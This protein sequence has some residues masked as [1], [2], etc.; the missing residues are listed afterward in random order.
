MTF[1]KGVKGCVRVAMNK[2]T[3]K[4]LDEEEE[5]VWELR[6]WNPWQFNW[7]LFM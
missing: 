3:K 4:K 7:N 1:A 5:V 6:I 2:L